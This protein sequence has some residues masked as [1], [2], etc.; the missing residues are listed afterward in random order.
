MKFIVK[1]ATPEGQKSRIVIADSRAEAM[2][3]VCAEYATLYPTYAV[4]GCSF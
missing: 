2:N 4:I 1:L 3:I